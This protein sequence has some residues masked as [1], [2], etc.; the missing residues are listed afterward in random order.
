MNTRILMKVCECEFFHVFF[1]LFK[2]IYYFSEL[3]RL[4]MNMQGKLN[5]ENVLNDWREI[6]NGL[7]LLGATGVEDRLQD[8][9]I[10]TMTCLREAG[11]KIW[12]LT[13]DKVMLNLQ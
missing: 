6:E 9:V 4:N 8:D 3:I 7:T 5:P 10:E 2:K 1:Y 12:V 11:I 13:G